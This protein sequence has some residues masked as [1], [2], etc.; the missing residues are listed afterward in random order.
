[1]TYLLFQAIIAVFILIVLL[2]FFTGWKITKSLFNRAKKKA[3]DAAEAVR[4]PVADADAA[5]ASIKDK[6]DDAVK[7]RK[8]LLTQ[9]KLSGTRATK[10]REEIVNFEK[11]AQLAG[12]AGNAND[13][14][15]ALNRKVDAENRLKSAE[16]DA[17]RFQDQENTLEGKIKE[18]D[19]L[20]TKA[21]QDK[22]YLQSALQISQFRN[23]VNAVLKDNSGDAQSA[24]DKLRDDAEQA[25]ALADTTDE[26]IAE[27]TNLN[28]YLADVPKVSDDDIAK[29]LV[30]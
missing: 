19:A 21:E 27:G 5:L 30:K 24:L 26:L 17:K 7:L 12:K 14:R 15:D 16:S 4:D 6:K 11:I 18:F 8:N 10:I 23:E 22:E 3:A 2:D 1:M 9:V 13:V 29:Y 28:K 25:Q 20:I